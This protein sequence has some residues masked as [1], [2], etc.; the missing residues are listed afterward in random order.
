LSVPTTLPSR[1]ERL[2]RHGATGWVLALLPLGRVLVPVL[3]GDPRYLAR[4]AFALSEDAGV[5]AV[6]ALVAVLS[7]SPLRAIFPS[8]GWAWGLNR[9]RRIVGV[10]AAGY[11]TAH[12]LGWAIDVGGWAGIPA[13]L[14]KP[15]IYLGLLAWLIL[16]VL[17]ITS[18]K[19]IVRRLGRRWKPLHRAVYLAAVLALIH[20]TMQARAGLGP[21]FWLFV[22]LGVLQLL[23]WALPQWRSR[24]TTE[25]QR[26]QR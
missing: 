17:A 1:L 8:A 21:T 24:L 16:L 19:G 15:F 12:L 11:A 7:L 14:D 25:S 9:H 3:S 4:P 13:E 26:A 2:L 5:A 18:L 23:R 10:A 20:Q 22:G 6:W